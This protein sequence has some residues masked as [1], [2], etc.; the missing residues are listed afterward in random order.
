MSNDSKPFVKTIWGHQLHS[1]GVTMETSTIDCEEEEC[2][3]DSTSITQSQN[4]KK[5][6]FP[7]KYTI[8]HLYR[9]LTPSISTDEDA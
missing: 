5:T 7:F 1:G 2:I 4:G 6:S 3:I 8:N 9:R